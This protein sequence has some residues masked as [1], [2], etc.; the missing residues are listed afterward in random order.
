MGCVLS[1][2]SR[3]LAFL[4]EVN[5]VLAPR[6]RIILSS[7]NP[8]YYWEAVVNIFYRHF[9]NRV[10]KSKHLEHFFEYSRYAMRTSLMRTGFT[11]EEEIGG[12]FTLVKTG[13]RFDVSRHPALAYEIIYAARKT[14][15]PQPFTVIE[16]ADG[17]TVP[18][19]TDLF[20]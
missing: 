14:G 20:A 1:H 12:G 11:L 7:T 13:W 16:D 15:M 5:R 10:S 18:F 2:L 8:H 3:P 4:A 6:G 19:E 9:K 17:K